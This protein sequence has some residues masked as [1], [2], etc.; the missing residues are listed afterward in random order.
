M[1]VGA[2]IE[3]RI[4]GRSGAKSSVL[5]DEAMASIEQR[6]PTPAEYVNLRSAV[7]WAVPDLAA[8]GEAL[9]CTQAAVCAVEAAE[10]L[11]W[12]GSLVTAGSTCSLWMWS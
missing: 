1:G 8:C 11:A 2:R 4:H 12:A 7:G 3:S 9:A 6:C 5:Q 10:W